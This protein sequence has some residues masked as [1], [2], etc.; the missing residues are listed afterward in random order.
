PLIKSSMSRVADKIAMIARSATKVVAETTM[1]RSATPRARDFVETRMGSGFP[2]GLRRCARCE[3]DRPFAASHVLHPI[4]EK[5][6]RG[7]VGLNQRF[8]NL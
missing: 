4:P 5:P 6:E 3:G 1:P 7:H 2:G 8:L